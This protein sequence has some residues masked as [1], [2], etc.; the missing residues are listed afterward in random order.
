M[1]AHKANGEVILSIC[2]PTYNRPREF[3]RLLSHLL[4]QL[5]ERME[6]VVRDDSETEASLSLF[7]R[8]TKEGNYTTQYYT[9]PKIG[10]DAAN[11]FLLE[12][13]KGKYMW[14]FSDDDILITGGIERA[15][16]L[17]ERDPGLS[18]IWANFGYGELAR[19]V[20]NRPDGYFRDANDVI[21]CLGVNIGL[22]STY[23]IKTSLGRLGL[24]YA[25]KHVRGFAFAS[26]AVV[27]WILTQP[28]RCYFMRGPYILCN[29]TT[30]EE[31]VKMTIREDGQVVNNA[32]VTY[33]VYFRDVIMG[34]S[35]RFSKASVRRLLSLNFGA[36][37]R[38][39]LVGWIG[40]W[41]SPEGKRLKMLNLYWTYP[42]CWI[43]I[44]LF[45]L[46]RPIV[47]QLYRIYGVFFSERRFVGL[48][49]LRS[50]T[51]L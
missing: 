33:G 40:G 44:G 5:D 28:G 30:R 41:D 4:P 42:E 12:K 17:I 36:L 37:W 9:G 18:F 23:I 29:P 21:G 38:G 22:L 13:A 7:E 46:P 51:K 39:M 47:S 15:V 6:V 35:G 10:L 27:V 43:A 2:I 20:V 19:M 31:I 48:R 34:Q 49:R 14:W 16:G 3:E 24:T 8:M 45:C 25:R 50:L 32:F 26:T 11:L 1:E